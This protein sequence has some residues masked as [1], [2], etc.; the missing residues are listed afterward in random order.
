MSYE[1]YLEKINKAWEELKDHPILDSFD[2][3]QLAVVKIFF[4]NGCHT[5]RDMYEEEKTKENF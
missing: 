1:D 2:S 5:V 3:T 4:L